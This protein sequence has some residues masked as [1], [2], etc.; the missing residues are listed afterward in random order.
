[1]Q[2]SVKLFI[3]ITLTDT[4][5]KRIVCLRTELDHV[6]ECGEN[7]PLNMYGTQLKTKGVKKNDVM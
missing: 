7:F 2:I 1:M 6:K 5:E 4:Q 3:I